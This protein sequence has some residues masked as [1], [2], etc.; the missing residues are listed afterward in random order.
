MA[1]SKFLH[2]PCKPSSASS[3][4]MSVSPSDPPQTHALSADASWLHSDPPAAGMLRRSFSR[5]LVFSA[6]A[7]FSNCPGPP[8]PSWPLLEGGCCKLSAQ[9]AEAGLAAASRGVRTALETARPDPFPSPLR[10]SR[11]RADPTP[12]ASVPQQLRRQPSRPHRRHGHQSSVTAHGPSARSHAGPA[13]PP[14]ACESRDE[15]SR[16]PPGGCAAP[17]HRRMVSSAYAASP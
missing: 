14:P 10:W 8:Q 16:R 12:R 11:G 17:S 6:V 5:F 2:Q 1:A 7:P 4:R 15:P 9:E 3:N 13:V